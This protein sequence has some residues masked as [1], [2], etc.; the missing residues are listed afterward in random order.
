MHLLDG[1]AQTYLFKHVSLPSE[2]LYISDHIAGLGWPR[3]LHPVHIPSLGKLS[4]TRVRFHPRFVEFV[5]EDVKDRCAVTWNMVREQ[6][7]HI[8]IT[9]AFVGRE[10]DPNLLKTAVVEDASDRQLRSEWD[11][12]GA[13]APNVRTLVLHREWHTEYFLACFPHLEELRLVSV[14]FERLALSGGSTIHHL[15]GA[16]ETRRSLGFDSPLR[17]V[18]QKC[19]CNQ[20]DL[21][22]LRGALEGELIVE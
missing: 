18:L 8:D 21:E 1:N 14:E 20:G 12:F 15:I 4:F 5:E 13:C 9:L 6:Y 2:S 17:L 11:N 3:I 10:S 7:V 19:H 16:V 22:T